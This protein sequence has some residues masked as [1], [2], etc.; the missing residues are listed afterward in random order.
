MVV[1]A[2]TVGG[3]LIYRSNISSARTL[4]NFPVM[5]I[6]NGKASVYYQMKITKGTITNHIVVSSLTG[7]GNE[8]T[9]IYEDIPKEIAQNASELDFKPKPTIVKDDPIILWDL[10]E[11]HQGQP[12]ELQ[13]T[14][15][16]RL[17]RTLCVDKGYFSEMDKLG[18]NAMY[19]ED[20]DKYIEMR[21]Q[22]ALARNKKRREQ[23]LKDQVQLVNPGEGQYQEIQAAAKKK[24]TDTEKA[25]AR[26]GCT[27]SK[28][29]VI[30]KIRAGY[31]EVTALPVYNN[32][33]A[34]CEGVCKKDLKQ[35]QIVCS[36]DP[37]KTEFMEYEFLFTFYV[38]DADGAVRKTGNYVKRRSYD[39]V[40]KVWEDWKTLGQPQFG[41]K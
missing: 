39:V 41:V 37:F 11:L 9:K 4:D 6:N 8:G 22:E 29:D 34:D 31:P 24:I 13:Y 3:F 5:L 28:E 19:P 12:V 33:V 16:K 27:G 35:W 23:E 26:K 15:K 32:I 25:T 14:Y 10:P 2:L 17:E 1:V 7:E 21:Y 18:L 36:R 38:G 40:K 30:S 20:C